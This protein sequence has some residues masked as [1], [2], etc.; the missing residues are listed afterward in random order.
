MATPLSEF[1]LQKLPAFFSN[2]RNPLGKFVNLCHDQPNFLILSPEDEN[3]YWDALYS[4][5]EKNNSWVRTRKWSVYYLG[6]SVRFFKF[7]ILSR[8]MTKKE[9]NPG[10]LSSDEEY[11]GGRSSSSK[12]RY[13]KTKSQS[14]LPRK[15]TRQAKKARL[16][17]SRSCLQ[18]DSRNV[19]EVCVKF[20]LLL[21]HALHYSLVTVFDSECVWAPMDE[22]D[23]ICCVVVHLL[24]RKLALNPHF[25]LL[26]GARFLSEKR[27]W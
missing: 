18:K 14:P 13:R 10:L 12:R 1:P 27:Y 8:R 17:G 25:V 16:L 26:S 19:D 24:C 11:C 15:S 21:I 7:L 22:N 9:N 2:P 5:S 4:G 20:L 23:F 6:C 3:L